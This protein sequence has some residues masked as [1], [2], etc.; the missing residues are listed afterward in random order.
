MTCRAAVRTASDVRACNLP[1]HAATAC[2][3][4]AAAGDGDERSSKGW[5]EYQ[6]IGGRVA[7]NYLRCDR[8]HN[9]KF[10]QSYR[11]FRALVPAERNA[12]IATG[13]WHSG[14]ANIKG[15]GAA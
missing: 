7:R 2:P 15:E 13:N 3:G 9:K 11:L 8:R 14:G 10:W 12:E 5:L 6:S 4:G 1:H